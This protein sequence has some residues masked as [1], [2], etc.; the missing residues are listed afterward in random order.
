MCSSL[1]FPY[2]SFILLNFSSLALAFPKT[3]LRLNNHFQLKQKFKNRWAITDFQLQTVIQL[4]WNPQSSPAVSFATR[5]TPHIFPRTIPLTEST[6]PL[7]FQ[8]AAS[9]HADFARSTMG[10]DIRRKWLERLQLTLTNKKITC[11][12]CLWISICRLIISFLSSSI[13]LSLKWIPDYISWL[14]IF[15]A[16]LNNVLNYEYNTMGTNQFV[17]FTH[18]GWEKIYIGTGHVVVSDCLLRRTVA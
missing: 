3:Q 16:Y 6:L 2:T 17:D 7:D 1:S 14:L 13:S 10:K 4:H 15:N 8:S 18:N 9:S 5:H 11:A 12:A